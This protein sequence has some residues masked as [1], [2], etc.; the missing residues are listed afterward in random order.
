VRVISNQRLR[1]FWE[2]RKS[3][4]EIAKRDL[5]VWRKLAENAIWTNYAS[6]K[7][8]F[9]SAD[10]VGGCV[11]FDAG[12]NRYRVICSVSYP[13]KKVY[14][15]KVMDHQE[16]DKKRWITDCGCHKRAVRRSAAPK[17]LVKSKVKHKPTP[18]RQKRES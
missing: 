3:D 8:T 1:E 14:I 11:V 6:L 5:S 16:Y 18:T 12:N 15:L 9:G 17:A 7:R 13:Q 10:T 2:S 4:S